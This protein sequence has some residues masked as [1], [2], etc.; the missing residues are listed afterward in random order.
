MYPLFNAA[1]QK[2]VNYACSASLSLVV[3]QSDARI[4]GVLAEH[5]HKK[6]GTTVRP[7]HVVTL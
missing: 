1:L 5:A 4:K 3:I 6:V 2:K 7:L